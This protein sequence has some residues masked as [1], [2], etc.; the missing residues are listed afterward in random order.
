MLG[1]KITFNE[2][3][4]ISDLQIMEICKNQLPHLLRYEDK[5]SMAF[6][7]ETRLPFL[8]YRLVEFLISVRPAYKL[9]KGWSKY[10]LRKSMNNR[11][12]DKITWRKNKMGFE[13]D[14]KE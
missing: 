13:L 8:D 14:E 1:K 3:E 7:I 9:F 11:L 10:L 12:P 4:S 2:F 6:S 5:N